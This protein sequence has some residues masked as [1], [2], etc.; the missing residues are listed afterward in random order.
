MAKIYVD[1]YFVNLTNI[2]HG[3]MHHYA[4]IKHYAYNEI[5]YQKGEAPS[6]LYIFLSGQLKIY[7][8]KQQIL[9]CIDGEFIGAHANFA[10]IRYPE[11]IKFSSPGVIFAIQFDYFQ[12][13]IMQYPLLFKGIIE[14]LIKK[15]KIVTNILD[16]QFSP[17][18]NKPYLLEKAY[19]EAM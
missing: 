2:L 10:N 19:S 6:H 3:D 1:S 14:G 4:S 13:K 8:E 9:D 12:E 5:L 7:R 16:K 15:Q 18:L 11:T 17:Y